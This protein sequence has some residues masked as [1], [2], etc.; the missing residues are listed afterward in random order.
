MRLPTQRKLSHE[1]IAI[2]WV[3][4]RSPYPHRQLANSQLP[5]VVRAK[6]SWWGW[7]LDVQSGHGE[8]CIDAQLGLRPWVK[9]SRACVIGSLKRAE[10]DSRAW[11]SCPGSAGLCVQSVRV[12]GHDDAHEAERILTQTAP[13]CLA[14][15]GGRRNQ[16][17]GA[18]LQ[19]RAHHST[20][21]RWR[22]HRRRRR[23]RRGSI[24]LLLVLSHQLPLIFSAWPPL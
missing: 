4:S 11:V 17:R 7:W 15:A 20:L 24:T 2:D 22:A 1:V 8:P 16:A 9:A 3:I 10:G 19:W 12:F 6:V 14:L 18:H 13:A 5:S 21:L 23:R